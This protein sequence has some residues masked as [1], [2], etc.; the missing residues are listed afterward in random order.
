VFFLLKP[1][2]DKSSTNTRLLLGL[3]YIAAFAHLSTLAMPIDDVNADDVPDLLN[4]SLTQQSPSLFDELV[5]TNPQFMSA[6]FA[7]FPP[8]N[9]SSSTTPASS[10][11]Q[12]ILVKLQENKS[13]ETLR[14]ADELDLNENLLENTEIP[15][16]N[17]CVIY[18]TNLN[19]T[20]S[21]STEQEQILSIR[22]D[23]ELSF[24]LSS[25]MN[26]GDLIQLDFKNDSS[27]SNND[28]LTT[29]AHFALEPRKE[30]IIIQCN[31]MSNQ[32]GH[33][34]NHNGEHAEDQIVWG[35]EKSINYWL[36]QNSWSNLMGSEGFFKKNNNYVTQHK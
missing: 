17:T 36:T 6:S 20:G 30:S 13:N 10:Y 33:V 32:L 5:V 7:P 2:D 11:F 35:H 34:V 18:L 19:V 9:N 24:K 4:S 23:S 25:L 26:D 12:A 16:A 1:Y 29:T 31:Q 21:N 15:P 28:I 14:A 22:T 8:E 27:N 3:F